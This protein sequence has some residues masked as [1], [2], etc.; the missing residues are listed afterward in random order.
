MSTEEPQQEEQVV[1]MTDYYRVVQ[2]PDPVDN[3][4][5][6]VIHNQYNTVEF[7]MENLVDALSYCEHGNLALTERLY[8]SHPNGPRLA[9]SPLTSATDKALN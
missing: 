4:N 9:V 6:W 2:V 8:L 1:H 3:I 7:K 5:W